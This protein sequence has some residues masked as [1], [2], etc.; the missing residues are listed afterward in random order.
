ML[1]ALIA[2]RP[3]TSQLPVVVAFLTRTSTRAQLPPGTSMLQEGTRLLASKPIDFHGEVQVATSYVL[4]PPGTFGSSYVVVV[5][6][7]PS[8]TLPAATLMPVPAPFAKSAVLVQRENPVCAV[9]AEAGSTGRAAPPIAANDRTAIIALRAR[10]VI[11]P[12]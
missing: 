5:V 7:E 2:Q 6:P 3:I 10:E 4:A 11:G 9:A 8:V 1:R 12:W